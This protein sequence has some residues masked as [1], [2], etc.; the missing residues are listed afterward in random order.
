MVQS[1]NA[2]C[3]LPDHTHEEIVKMGVSSILE[4]ISDPRYKSHQQ[5]VDK[6]E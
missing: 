5:E 4:G 6:M 2:D 1:P 3:D